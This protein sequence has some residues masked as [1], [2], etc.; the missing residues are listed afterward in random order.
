MREWKEKVRKC[1]ENRRKLEE[2]LK[3]KNMFTCGI[4]NDFKTVPIFEGDGVHSRCVG[5]VNSMYEID[6]IVWNQK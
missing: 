2:Y 5:H 4:K 1:N 3:N 6:S